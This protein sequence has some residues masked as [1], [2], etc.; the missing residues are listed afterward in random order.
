LLQAR[1]EYSD[2]QGVRRRITLSWTGDQ[3]EVGMPDLEES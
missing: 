2:A 3:V 1:L